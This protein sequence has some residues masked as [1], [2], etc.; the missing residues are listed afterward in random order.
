METGSAL[1]GGADV[2]IQ[3][4]DVVRVV[5][6]LDAREALV[7]GRPVA[8]ENSVVGVLRLPVDVAADSHRMWL[9]RFPKRPDPLPL[10]LLLAGAVGNPND[11]CD[12][13]G[14]GTTTEDRIIFS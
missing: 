5:D 1:H 11:E 14:R 9:E 6:C 8:A 3:V 10:S 7:L 12:I 2:G 4:E 13:A